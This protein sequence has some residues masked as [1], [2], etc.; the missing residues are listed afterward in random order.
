MLKLLVTPLL[1]ITVNST[2]K[3][4]E[5]K[6]FEKSE[7]YIAKMREKERILKT[8]LF[9]K[10]LE[11]QLLYDSIKISYSL[12]GC[13]SY[14]YFKTTIKK[15]GDDYYMNFFLFQAPDMAI[16]QEKYL[17]GGG[18]FTTIKLTPSDWVQ[19]KD[20]L[21]ENKKYYSTMHNYI[22]IKQGDMVYELMDNNPEHPL[23]NFIEAIQKR[24]SI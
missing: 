14:S 17:N 20:A 24:K 5:K 2:I 10:N 9:I 22:F 12:E 1:F 19:L 16:A 7:R 21:V 13:F 23:I 8:S 15:L 11:Y 18:K 4:V 6:E 3:V